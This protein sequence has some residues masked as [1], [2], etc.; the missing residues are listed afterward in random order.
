LCA[1]KAGL[2]GGQQVGEAHDAIGW[3]NGQIDAANP[4]FRALVIEVL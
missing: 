4:F 3:S 2:P 1:T